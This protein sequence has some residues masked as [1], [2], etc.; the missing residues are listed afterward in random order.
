MIKF[1]SES[2]RQKSLHCVVSA[3]CNDISYRRGVSAE[4][5]EERIPR[6][7]PDLLMRV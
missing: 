6:T 5:E 3:F 4:E 2:D 1:R 7:A